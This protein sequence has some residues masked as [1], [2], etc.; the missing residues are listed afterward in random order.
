[1]AGNTFIMTGTTFTPPERLVNTFPAN[2]NGYHFTEAEIGR[3]ASVCNGFTFWI[4]D[5]GCYSAKKDDV[6]GRIFADNFEELVENIS[7]Y[8][9]Q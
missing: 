2:K 7:I 5:D 9:S 4:L 1:M 3:L 6:D 8:L